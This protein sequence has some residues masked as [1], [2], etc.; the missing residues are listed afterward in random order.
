MY[1]S[2][3]HFTSRHFSK[4]YRFL[5]WKSHLFHTFESTLW[6]GK[7]S[8]ACLELLYCENNGKWMT[9]K[10]KAWVIKCGSWEPSGE[11]KVPGKF[12]WQITMW[13]EIGFFVSNICKKWKLYAIWLHDGKS[14]FTL[15]IITYKDGLQGIKPKIFH[16]LGNTFQI[17]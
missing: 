2:Y 10:S 17:S 9:A 5:T 16:F 13:T 3:H 4:W 15:L 7:K 8:K 11:T 1:V 12:S 14:F 6:E